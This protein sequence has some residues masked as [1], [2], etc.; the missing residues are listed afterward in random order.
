MVVACE[1]LPESC[2]QLGGRENG[3]SR[4][5]ELERQ[6]QIV[7]PSAKLVDRPVCL[8][9]RLHGP[10]PHDEKG[11]RLAD[12]GKPSQIVEC[13]EAYMSSRAAK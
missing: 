6:G 5:R 11:N 13:A 9:V 2:Q 3:H 10:R 1:P 7:E 12:H 4:S 8:E